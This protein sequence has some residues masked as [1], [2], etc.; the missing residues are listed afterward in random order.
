MRYIISHKAAADQGKSVY[1]L[2]FSAVMASSQEEAISRF[3]VLH[4]DR[5]VVEAKPTPDERKAFEAYGLGAMTDEEQADYRARMESRN[6]LLHDEHD[7]AKQNVSTYTLDELRMEEE[8]K[9]NSENETPNQDG[10]HIGDIFYSSWGYDQTNVDFFQVVDL[11]GKRTAVVQEI[12]AKSELCGDWSGY[13]RP[14]RD[15]FK[16]EE[17]YTVRTRW[18]D[19]YNQPQMKN[20]T[21]GGPHM[22]DPVEFGKLYHFS[23]GA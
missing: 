1:M 6:A 10:V 4:P 19:Y 12:N 9:A 2:T 21:L 3:S 23:T 20:P 8:Y 18:N 22:M 14:I 15:A 5:I 17:R 7:H 11:K 13:T 16:D